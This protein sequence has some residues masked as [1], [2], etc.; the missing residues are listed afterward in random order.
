MKAQQAMPGIWHFAIFVLRIP[1]IWRLIGLANQPNPQ[2]PN[3]S[4][5]ANWAGPYHSDTQRFTAEILFTF[6]SGAGQ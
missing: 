1:R 3:D 4:V 6:W 5:K 2:S